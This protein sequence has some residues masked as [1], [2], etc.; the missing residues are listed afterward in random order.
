MMSNNKINNPRLLIAKMRAGDYAH[1]GEEE[2]IEIVLAGIDKIINNNEISK[3]TDETEKLKV[4]DIGCGLG[5]TANYIK[6]SRN[7]SVCGIDIDDSAIQYA[8]KKYKD[9]PFFNCDVLD[10]KNKFQHGQFDVVYMLNSFYAFPDQKLALKLLSQIT[11]P[12]G[13]LVIFEY[14]L[15]EDSQQSLMLDLAGI[16][17]K[18]IVINKFQEILSN[19]GWELINIINLNDKFEK[20]Y[21]KFLDKLHKNKMTILNEFDEASF[22]K[23]EDAFLSILGRIKYGT[24]GGS[25]YY[26]RSK[27]N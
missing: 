21:T 19:S 4:I 23:V 9:I 6:N 8:K 5:G 14:T 25:I 22:R 20:W 7:Y 26:A 13:L 2:A 1:A 11:K 10:V 12:H 16:T 24:L 27:I 15:K 17:M 18:P 3:D